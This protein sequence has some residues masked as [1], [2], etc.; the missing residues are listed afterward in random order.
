MKAFVH[1]IDPITG[2]DRLGT[3]LTAG[4]VI[5]EYPTLSSLL[6]NGMKMHPPG[7]YHVEAFRN[8]DRRYGTPDIDLIITKHATGEITRSHGNA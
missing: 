3:G 4:T 1:Y 5:G 2:Q 8:W 6:D 7:K